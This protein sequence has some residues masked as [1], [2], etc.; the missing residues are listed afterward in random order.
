M[1]KKIMLILRV[2]FSKGMLFEFLYFLG[3]P[4]WISKKDSK[5]EIMIN[6]TYNLNIVSSLIDGR[7][8]PGVRG[9]GYKGV[10][11]LSTEMSVR[12]FEMYAA[13]FIS[14]AKSKGDPKREVALLSILPPSIKFMMK[15]LDIIVNKEKAPK[16]IKYMGKL[17]PIINPV[18]TGA[19]K[20]KTYAKFS[21]N[22]YVVGDD[23]YLQLDE[24][25]P[26]EVVKIMDRLFNGDEF[27][28]KGVF[29][30]E[31]PV[32]WC[33]SHMGLISPYHLN[34]VHAEIVTGLLQGTITVDEL[35]E[36]QFCILKEVELLVSP[37]EQALKVEKFEQQLID[38]KTFLAANQY[39]VLNTHFNLIQI[40][41][42]R[43]YYKELLV[44]G[45][46]QPSDFQVANRN[47]IHNE[48]YSR[49]IHYQLTELLDKI[50]PEP[51]KPSYCFLAHYY[52]GAVL[53]KHKDRKQCEWNVSMPL[54][55]SPHADA[56]NSWPI[57]IQKDSDE[58][59]EVK[60][61]V[62]DV[63]IY[64][65]SK[66]FHWRDMLEVDKTATVCFF[67][68]VNDKFKVKLD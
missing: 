7:G 23:I 36:E 59:M 66:L 9:V 40:N 14:L 12:E 8:N 50:L 46:F 54:D 33:V 35:S 16:A 22:D 2:M 65:G 64:R 27:D 47:H 25:V 24:Q 43:Q 37:K 19:I 29:D 49:F 68:F 34:H 67:H 51:V 3:Q 10:D 38:A 11:S 30:D 4:W 63:V 21:R 31:P 53:E 56:N 5:N 39:L 32:V 42:Q 28:I 57:Y 44:R 18:G 41:S 45:Y 60:L 6:P 13:I 15:K 61:A 52:G 26:V 20:E 17:K 55:Y 48:A 58:I 1:L 62:G